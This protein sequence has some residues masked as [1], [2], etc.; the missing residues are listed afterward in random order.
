MRKVYVCILSRMICTWKQ[1]QI[2]FLVPLHIPWL[3]LYVQAYSKIL[4]SPQNSASSSLVF[5]RICIDNRN[6]Y[7]FWNSFAWNT[8]LDTLNCFSLTS[9]MIAPEYTISLV[10]RLF[11]QM[12]ISLPIPSFHL[13]Q[14]T[15]FVYTA[16]KF[17]YVSMNIFFSGLCT[18]RAP[19]PLLFG[20]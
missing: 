8:H 9:T 12:L 11:L 4:F 10:K 20:L 19:V 15:F 3:S 17:M 2:T 18:Y 14:S 5:L 1:L 7:N 16:R 13:L 6:G